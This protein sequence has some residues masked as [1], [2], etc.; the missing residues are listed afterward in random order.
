MGRYIDQAAL[1][2]RLT[3]T[4]LAALFN[5]TGDGVVNTDAVEA[6]IED[7]EGEAEG[8]FGGQY[9]IPL[10]EPNDRLL[11][12]SVLDLAVAFSYDRAPEYVRTFAEQARDTGLYK[13]AVARLLRIKAALQILPDQSG[14][15]AA[16]LNVGGVVTD[17]GPRMMIDSADGTANNSGF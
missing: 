12:K 1:E 16:P 3:P 13:R 15:A 2:L 17:N 4:T 5:D 6:I 10:P 7:A 9:P 8:F 14:G 11:R